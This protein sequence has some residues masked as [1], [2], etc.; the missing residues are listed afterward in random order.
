MQ[1]N[2]GPVW[3]KNPPHAAV[4][5]LVM[6]DVKNPSSHP[7][8]EARKAQVQRE[9]SQEYSGWERADLRS[10]PAL[11]A[12]DRFYRQFRKTYHLQLQLESIVAGKPIPSVSALVEAMFMAELEDHLLTAGHDLDRVEPPIEIELAVGDETYTRMNGEHQTLKQGDLYVRDEQG[13]LS[14]IIYG[15]DKRSRIQPGTQNVLFTT[16]A[17]PGIDRDSLSAH[18]AKLQGYVMLFSPEASTKRL[19]IIGG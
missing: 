11:A 3:R 15:P 7:T 19:E 8:L 2:L 10:L 17:V 5:I 1:I 6:Q 4:G 16:Y 14:S 13:I 18:L 12:Y 9:I